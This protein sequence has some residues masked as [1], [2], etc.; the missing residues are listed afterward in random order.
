MPTTDISEFCFFAGTPSADKK[1]TVIRKL[2][3][4]KGTYGGVKDI[5]PKFAGY[6]RK[7]GADAIINDTRL[8][9]IWFLSVANGPPCCP[10]CSNKVVRSPEA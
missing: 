8:A 9:K 1:Y 4:G 10:R 3:L 2:R 6:A 7:A 5:L